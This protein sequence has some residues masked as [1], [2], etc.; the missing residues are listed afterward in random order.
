M[1]RIA[2]IKRPKVWERPK[3][4][5]GVFHLRFPR[6]QTLGWS[7]AFGKC[8]REY[9]WDHRLWRSQGN[10]IRQKKVLG[11]NIATP[12]KKPETIS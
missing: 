10:R 6:K 7:L 8:I 12:N 11:C 1:E 5:Q 9:P 2:V 4:L 3:D